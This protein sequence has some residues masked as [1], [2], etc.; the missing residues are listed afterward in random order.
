[1]D[2]TKVAFCDIQKADSE[3][4]GPFDHLKHCLLDL[5]EVAFC[6]AQE[7]ENVFAW[8]I[9]PLNHRFIDY[10]Q[11]RF[12]SDHKTENEFSI[13]P[14]SHFVWLRVENLFAGTVNL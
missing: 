1:M 3:F 5:V 4:S 10:T 7:A 9:D 2:F 13:S 6:D 14:K 11:V 8:P 12:W